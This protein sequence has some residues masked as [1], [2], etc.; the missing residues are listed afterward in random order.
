MKNK[1]LILTTLSLLTLVSP[2]FAGKKKNKEAAPKPVANPVMTKY[3]KDVNGTLDD[4][5]KEAMREVLASATALKAYDKNS[6]GAL[7]DAEL[8]EISKP[9][10]VP[11]EAPKKKK[12]K[13]K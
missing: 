1:V 8:A 3:D 13:N 10:A 4:A 7:D 2:S 9:P 12:K 5:E 6:D 11:A